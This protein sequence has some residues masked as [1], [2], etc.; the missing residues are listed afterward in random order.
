MLFNVFL[1]LFW[2]GVFLY[3]LSQMKE[4]VEVTQ[5]QSIH[6][7]QIEQYYS[8]QERLLTTYRNLEVNQAPFHQLLSLY[9]SQKSYLVENNV[10]V[11]EQKMA[12]IE[13]NV[14]IRGIYI[15][16]DYWQNWTEDRL[17][18]EIQ[19]K[20]LELQHKPKNILFENSYQVILIQDSIEVMRVDMKNWKELHKVL[21]IFV[22]KLSEEN[23]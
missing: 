10:A 2:A 19:T 12:W 11:D 17:N 14:D 18:R 1:G 9:Y 15:Q 16:L 23:E 3:M 21:S 8:L 5:T 20:I 4:R 22:N 13:E 6:K 7:K